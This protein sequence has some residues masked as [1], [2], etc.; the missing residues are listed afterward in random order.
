MKSILL[1]LLVA[2]CAARELP[3]PAARDCPDLPPLKS[4]AT[5]A[6]M[7]AH[8]GVIANLYARCAATP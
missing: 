4:G 1:C 2:G 5:T 6:D 8:I 7:R 3:A